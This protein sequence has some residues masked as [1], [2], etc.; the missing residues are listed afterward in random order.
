MILAEK[1][2]KLRKQNGW[3]QE[4]LAMRLNI[5]R[6]S[7]SKWESASSIPDLDK[8]IRL[9]EIFGVST[10][11]LLKDELEED[12]ENIVVTDTEGFGENRKVRTVSL[13]EANDYMALEETSAKRIAAGVSACILSPVLL[14]LM[15]GLAEYQKIN[16]TENMAGGTGV[17][18]LLLIIAGA[19]AVFIT[20]GMKLEKYGYMEKEILSLEYGIAGIVETKRDSFEMAY[21]RCIVAGVALCIL[22][23]VPIFVAAAFDSPEIVYIYCVCFLLVLIS[24]A[25]FLFVWSGIIYGSYQKLLEEGEY[26]R[27]KKQENKNNSNL[28]K[29]YWCLATVIYLGYSFATGKWEISWIIWPCAGIL[30]AAV[31]GIAAM[32]RKR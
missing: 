2:T 23:A 21:K 17:S 22:S 32:L 9:S 5:S 27:E 31:C 20:E 28:A 13:E 8:I 11:Y 12:M 16:M 30:Y 29:V 3:S 4:E 18:I 25:V 10:D 14:I 6:Q 24:L 19:V 1:I 7:V 26:T 15:S